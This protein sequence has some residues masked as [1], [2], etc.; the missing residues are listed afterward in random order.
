[1]LKINSSVWNSIWI[2][3]YSMYCD[4]ASFSSSYWNKQLNGFCC[5]PKESLL[6][7]VRKAELIPNSLHEEKNIPKYPLL[8][9]ISIILLP[10]YYSS[11]LTTAPQP[12][13][14]SAA[15]QEKIPTETTALG[16]SPHFPDSMI[17]EPLMK[18]FHCTA[19]EEKKGAAASCRSR[20]V[21]VPGAN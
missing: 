17:P 9:K 1:M 3:Q 10:F 6:L 7:S 11:L 8:P 5:N 4:A 14:C 2:P 20:Q 15:V 16:F 12:P 21:P 18:T 13:H 19:G